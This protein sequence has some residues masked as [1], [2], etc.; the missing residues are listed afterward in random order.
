MVLIMMLIRAQNGEGE[1]LVLLQMTASK[2]TDAVCWD[3]YHF[4]GKGF[5]YPSIP[6]S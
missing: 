1:Q 6:H 3:Q 2:N 4:Q 5:T